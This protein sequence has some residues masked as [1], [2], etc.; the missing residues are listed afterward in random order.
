M[1]LTSNKYKTIESEAI[2]DQVKS[3]LESMNVSNY[4][5]QKSVGAGTRE[6]Y[7]INLHAFDGTSNTDGITPRIIL[8]NSYAGE[9]ALTIHVGFLR[10][11]C[12]NGMVAG[13]A[14]F[15]ERIIHRQG[16]TAERKL[17][18][19]DYGIVAALTY[20]RDQFASDMSE[21]TATS[22]E[23]DQMRS[24]VGSLPQ[25]SKR[26][27]DRVINLIVKPGLR[28]E[29]DRANNLWTLW[30]LVNEETGKA[31]RSVLRFAAKNIGLLNDIKYL[32]EVA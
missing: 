9:T 1:R 31:S 6:V 3:T 23:E 26:S 32:A 29:A 11:A 19:L 10:W 14:F 4:T 25:L 2:V 30:N 22:M 27:K 13:D 21:L 24:V 12:S 7:Y 28:R 20:L 8:F 5:I 17:K 16:K 15:S 18:Q